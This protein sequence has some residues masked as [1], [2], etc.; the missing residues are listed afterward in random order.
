MIEEKTLR[1]IKKINKAKTLK[2]KPQKKTKKEGK[3]SNKKTIV[4]L[5]DRRQKTKTK[6]ATL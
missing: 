2:D 4:N 5:I 6:N 1:M 3:N